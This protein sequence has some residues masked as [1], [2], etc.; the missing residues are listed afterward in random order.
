MSKDGESG[1]GIAHQPALGVRIPLHHQPPPAGNPLRRSLR[2]TRINAAQAP[3]ASRSRGN[4]HLCEKGSPHPLAAS[5]PAPRPGAPPLGPLANTAGTAAVATRPTRQHARRH[6][7]THTRTRR[8]VGM[9]WMAGL[10]KAGL[11]L[12][13]GRRVAGGSGVPA[14]RARLRRQWSRPQATPRW[15]ASNAHDM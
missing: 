9:G 4:T 1:C 14:E 12:P 5:K 3:A 15:R 8:A 2:N 7:H 6:T 11:S 13:R 10:G